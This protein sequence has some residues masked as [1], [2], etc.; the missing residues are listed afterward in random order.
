[1]KGETE[2][3]KVHEDD[4]LRF[5]DRLCVPANDELKEKILNEAHNSWRSV[6]PGA[7]KMYQGIR[8]IKL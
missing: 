1:M 6:H 8:S 2:A 4:G 5:Q 7:T 3:F